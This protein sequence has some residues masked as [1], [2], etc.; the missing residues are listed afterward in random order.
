MQALVSYGHQFKP[1]VLYVRTTNSTIAPML[2][3]N[4]LRIPIVV[5]IN[6][7][8]RGEI[9]AENRNVSR[10]YLAL[11]DC[12]ERWR[13]RKA[14]GVVAITRAIKSHIENVYRIEEGKISVVPNGVNP[15]IIV[16]MERKDCRLRLGIDKTSLCVGFVGKMMR[17][18]GLNYLLE[19][20]QRIKKE[21]RYPI[22]YLFVGSGDQADFLKR[23][24][25]NLGLGDCVH[26][27]GA[28]PHAEIPQYLG[29][30]D[31]CYLYKRED[32]DDSS[33]LKLYEYLA[34]ARPVIAIDMPGISEIVRKADCGYLF[35]PDS[36][37]AICECIIKA[38][39]NWERLREMGSR[40]RDAVISEYT[41]AKAAEKIEVL[42]EKVLRRS[43][44]GK[45]NANFHP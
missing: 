20:A 5:E 6:G 2:V 42:L 41:W 9:L 3:A 7:L 15:S 22:R 35:R 30:F 38:W 16:P 43:K 39:Q 19:A 11:V 29:A 25:N 13:C 28:V 33:P 10:T 31:I 18:Q 44:G 21:H 14:D 45:Q 8:V 36:V 40:G 17:W 1:E 4:L 24:A 32:C 37:V 12:L 34:A 27:F 23:M 26:F